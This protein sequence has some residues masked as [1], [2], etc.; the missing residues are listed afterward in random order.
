[1]GCGGAGGG[2]GGGTGGDRGRGPFRALSRVDV[3]TRARSARAIESRVATR[4]RAPP[5]RFA[6]QR[7]ARQPTRGVQRVGPTAA[8]RIG[9]PDLPPLSSPPARRRR[10]GVRLTPLSVARFVTLMPFGLWNLDDNIGQQ[11]VSFVVLLL[12]CVVFGGEL[13][14]AFTNS[15]SP[16][17]Y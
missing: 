12:T 6:L 16:R 3:P 2:A 14:T 8:P 17:L 5:A 11:I 10:P 9:A 7:R 4:M 1:M 13:C 15:S